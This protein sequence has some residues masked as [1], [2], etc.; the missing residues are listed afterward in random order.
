MTQIPVVNRASIQAN[1]FPLQFVCDALLKSHQDAV[2]Q[3]FNFY[4]EFNGQPV[5]EKSD[6]TQKVR[7]ITVKWTLEEQEF[8]LNG[9]RKF[10]KY[11]TQILKEYPMNPIRI[12][13]DLKDKWKNLQKKASNPKIKELFERIEASKAQRN[14]NFTKGSRFILINEQNEP[15]QEKEQIILIHKQM[16]ERISHRSLSFVYHALENQ[17]EQTRIIQLWEKVMADPSTVFN[18]VKECRL[19]K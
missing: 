10:E 6:K 7:R 1:E 3:P 8:L 17:Q 2:K 14:Q 4:S 13:F 5:E 16:E 19:I 12:R 18:F 9:Y 15:K 11:W